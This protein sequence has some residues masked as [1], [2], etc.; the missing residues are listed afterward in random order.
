MILSSLS[1]LVKALDVSE[2]DDIKELMSGDLEA[3]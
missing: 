3:W 1:N 2:R